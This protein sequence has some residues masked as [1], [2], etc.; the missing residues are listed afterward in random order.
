MLDINGQASEREQVV[1]TDIEMPCLQSSTGSTINW[2]KKVKGAVVVQRP[3]FDST[4][5]W[6]IIYLFNAGPMAVDVVATI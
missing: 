3:A 5:F 6:I 1:V 2:L 4:N